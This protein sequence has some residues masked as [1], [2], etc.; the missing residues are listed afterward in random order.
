MEHVEFGRVGRTIADRSA[1]LG[2]Q[3]MERA[4]EQAH[5]TRLFRW[6]LAALLGLTFTAVVFTAGFL[7]GAQLGNIGLAAAATEGPD[8]S[9]LGAQTR[10]E[11][12]EDVDMAVF[13]EV[14]NTLERQYFGELPDEEERIQ[15][16]ITGL[17]NS[18]G[19]PYTAYIPPS[20]AD[21][22]R[23]DNTGEFEGIGAF[24]QEAP[25]GGVF[26]VR[27]FEDGPAE[28]AGIR[29]GDVIV[30]VDGVD[31]TD[32][33]LNEALVMIRGKAGTEV[34]LTVLRE[35][36]DELIEVTVKR[37][38]LQ[39]PT[40]EAEMLED[41]IGYVSL[42]QFNA[43]ATDRL[44]E[45]VEDLLDQGAQAIILDLRNNPGG[46]LDQAVSVADLFLPRSLVLIERTVTGDVEEFRV[47]SGDLAEEVPLVVLVNEGSASAAEIVAAAI[48]DNGRGVLIGETT[49]GKG[50]VQLIYNLSDEG[51][52]RVTYAEWFTPNDTSISENGVQPDIVVEMDDDTLDEDVED[53]QLERA[54]EYLQEERVVEE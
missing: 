15:G 42:Y 24:V 32:K 39:I 49:F 1:R 35:G 26:I 50:S 29:A 7:T 9:E 54:I 12:P 43:I 33:I 21:I 45:A 48:Q 30:E 28:Q 6:A 37:A 5:R 52:L 17:V 14:W 51:Q 8:L 18:L 10:Q 31:I 19:D 22:L 20:I 4:D 40:V 11:Q 47:S 41:D 34:D 27:V 25:E 3:M 36:E 38:R 53:I 2:I 13:W 23:E 44:T 16:A 46:F